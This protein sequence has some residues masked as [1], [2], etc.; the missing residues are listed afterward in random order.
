MSLNNDKKGGGTEAD[1]SISRN[2]CSNC[3][4]NGRFTQ[5]EL[6]A[7]QMQKRLERKM[8]ELNIPPFVA[9]LFTRKIPKLAR[10]NQNQSR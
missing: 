6:T 9:R 4:R 2:Y 8:R 3:Y 5:P 7:C 1:G 10:W